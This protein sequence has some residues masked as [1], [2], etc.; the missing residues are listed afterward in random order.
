MFPY[1]NN[2]A[3]FYHFQLTKLIKL[4]E[5]TY[6]AIPENIHTHPWTTLESCKKCLVSMTGNP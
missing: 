3:K 2:I 1:L 5:K 4:T 6:W